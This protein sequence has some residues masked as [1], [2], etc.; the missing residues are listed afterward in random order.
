MSG[1]RQRAAGTV[2]RLLEAAD[3][4]D[5]DVTAIAPASIRGDRLAKRATHVEATV[6]SLAAGNDLDPRVE[7]QRAVAERDA[8]NRA[9]AIA[10]VADQADAAQRKV[11]NQGRFVDV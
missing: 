2:R 10:V 7:E 11:A 9:R 4:R 3:E 1:V 5:G 8:P 6:R